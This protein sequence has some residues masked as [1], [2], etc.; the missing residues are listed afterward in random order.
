MN[1]TSTA[2]TPPGAPASF[3]IGETDAWLLAEGKH[4]RPWQKLGAHTTVMDGVAGTAFAV[5]A[6]HARHVGLTGDFNGWQPQSMRFRPE[7]GVWELFV[8]GAGAGAWYKFEVQGI[9]GRHVMKTDPYARE[10][11]LPP[12]NAARVCEPLRAAPAPA[13]AHTR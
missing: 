2:P 9:D 10:T 8:P 12:G 13:A 1:P 4:L 5:W 3:W 6:P 7:C 11:E